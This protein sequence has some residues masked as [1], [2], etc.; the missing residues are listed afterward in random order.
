MMRYSGGIIDWTKVG[1]QNMDR[2][3]RKI[4]TLNRCLHPRS[5]V[6][7]LYMKWKVGQG[8]L[9]TE[10]KCII[11]EMRGLY[12]YLKESKTWYTGKLQGQFVEETKDIADK[13]LGR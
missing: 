5:S 3:T 4:M 9:I 11:A 6:A 10:D 8:G 1:L 12:D 7:R 2:K 13:R